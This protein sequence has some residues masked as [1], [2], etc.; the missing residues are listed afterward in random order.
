MPCGITAGALL[1]TNGDN[2]R[3]RYRSLV[4]D[5]ESKTRLRLK[6]LAL[7]A[8]AYTKQPESFVVYHAELQRPGDGPQPPSSVATTSP[9]IPKDD[10]C[11]CCGYRPSYLQ[12]FRTSG[13]VLA[14]LCSMA[15]TDSFVVSGCLI[16][17]LP[18]I[19][20]RF[21]LSS[22]ESGTIL[23][24]Y[25]VVNCIIIVPVA[26][27]GSKRNKPV[28]ISSGMV[29]IATGSLVFTLC[30]VLAPPYTFSRIVEDLCTA[31]PQYE[32][33]QCTNDIVSN[34]RFLLM[35]G[36]MLHGAGGAPLQTLG[37]SF[38]DENLPPRL[39]SA[40]IG[41]FSSMAVLGP[42]CGFLVGG[43]FLTQFVDLTDASAVGLTENSSVWVGAW[44]VGF[45]IAT[46]LGFVLAVPMAAFPKRTA[47]V[48]DP[49]EGLHPCLRL[50]VV[51]RLSA[52]D[53]DDYD[54]VKS[55]L[56]KRY[57]LSAEAFRQR[58]RNASKKSSEG[59][60]EFAYGLKTNLIEWLKSEKVYESRDKVVEC[61]CLEQFFRSIPQSVKLWVQDRVGVDSVERAAEL[62]EEYATR[63]KLSGE[64]SESGRSD[65][66][67][68]FRQGGW[69]SVFEEREL[70]GGVPLAHVSPPGSSVPRA[71][72]LQ[73]EPPE[74]L[75]VPGT[76]P[77][78]KGTPPRSSP[79]LF[80]G[81]ITVPE[82]CLYPCF[83]AWMPPTVSPVP[84]NSPSLRHAP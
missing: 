50:E 37:V 31:E 13:W 81:D 70:G 3:S 49:P 58:F 65:Q 57:R 16:V 84:S 82:Q 66:R 53:A 11:G 20:R 64:E 44:W 75:P 23:S 80:P 43:Y 48:P 68:T 60:S 32:A 45:A 55:S 8:L 1:F 54:K 2:G 29:L 35:V 77:K 69:P 47:V 7:P 46:V 52:G 76:R 73:L 26:F 9:Q 12:C 30:Y 24:G 63:R 22:F 42:V 67:K 33:D 71:L 27:L 17:V 28:I 19:E 51:A 41:A 15:F 21:H 83:A 72:P 34:F 40:Y 39:T 10:M 25:N 78:K 36:S 61:V 38:L 6:P 59:Y 5:A 74:H 62:A 56:L 79:Q 14:S 18:T 4:N